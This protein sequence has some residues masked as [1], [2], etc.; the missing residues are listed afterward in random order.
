MSANI[1]AICMVCSTHV[2][3]CVTCI[4]LIL[5]IC[6]C[7]QNHCVSWF[8]SVHAQ[9]HV[10]NF[11]AEDWFT[12]LYSN[13][14]VSFKVRYQAIMTPLS[15]HRCRG[16]QMTSQSCALQSLLTHERK[17]SLLATPPD[18]TCQSTSEPTDQ[19]ADQSINKIHV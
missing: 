16:G 9:L 12:R 8:K 2:C 5:K 3:A 17:N 10:P 11:V 15:V 13:W 19:S 18:S 7:G 1:K 4:N 14:F 6:E